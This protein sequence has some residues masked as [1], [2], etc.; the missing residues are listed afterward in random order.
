M[1]RS[2]DW[3]EDEEYEDLAGD[4]ETITKE[5]TSA[6]Q[7]QPTLFAPRVSTS[8]LRQHVLTPET[9]P[10]VPPSSQF[11][12]HRATELTRLGKELEKQNQEV[13]DSVPTEF[14]AFAEFLA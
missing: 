6:A 1:V 13:I 7:V 4:E 12:E 14:K 3:D 10:L 8:H 2:D 9:G 5:P 11:N